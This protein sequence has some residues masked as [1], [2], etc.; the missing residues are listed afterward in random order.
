MC[1]ECARRIRD[2]T[3]A[4]TANPSGRLSLGTILAFAGTSLPL[5][6]LAIAISVYLPRYFASH[7]GVELAVVGAVFALVRA[8]DIPLDPALGMIMD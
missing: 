5:S 7:I 4:N 3:Q 1:A 2:L 8:I 6:A